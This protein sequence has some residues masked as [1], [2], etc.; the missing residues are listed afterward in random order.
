MHRRPDFVEHKPDPGL[1]KPTAGPSS[2]NQDD[3]RNQDHSTNNRQ[4]STGNDQPAKSEPVEQRPPKRDTP[5]NNRP[6]QSNTT[7]NATSNPKNVPQ[8]NN[9]RPMHNVG[10]VSTNVYR[11]PPQKDQ[12]THAPA[13]ALEQQRKP[14]GNSDITEPAT[15]SMD[16][17]YMVEEDDATFFES[18]DER[19]MMGDFDIDLD[20]DLG[21]P[22]EFEAD[23]SVTNHDDSGFQEANISSGN[24]DPRRGIPTG[25]GPGVSAQRNGTV[26]VSGLNENVG[27]TGLGSSTNRNNNLGRPNLVN[28]T[29]TGATNQNGNGKNDNGNKEV[30]LRTVRFSGD[31]NDR[32][33][34]S[35]AG[36]PVGGGN[37]GRTTP[38]NATS[39][40]QPSGSGNGRPSAGGFS[41]PPGVVRVTFL[42][43]FSD[44]RLT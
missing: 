26:S 38:S 21:R 7:T 14:A 31:G 11:P 13:A 40:V 8:Q 17:D 34:R 20:V 32:G 22:I 4:A 37:G 36:L 19:W 5:T 2:V 15:T 42:L 16:V 41:F 9:T 23:E 27:T 30:G 10:N 44:A 12:P 1:V 29:S 6:V 28:P 43:K 35:N 39:S 18:E 24:G 3:C 25:S 33:Q